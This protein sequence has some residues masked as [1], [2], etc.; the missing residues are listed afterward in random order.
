M[1]TLLISAH[2]VCESMR[3]LNL[4]MASFC[5]KA[6]QRS[7]QFVDLLTSVIEG[8]RGADCALD[9]HAAQDGL[10]AMVSRAYRY[11]LL[12]QGDPN[13]FRSKIVENEREHARLLAGSSDEAQSGYTEQFLGAVI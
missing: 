12:V 2:V 1:K 7:H 4:A 13:I 10:R 8:K 6:Q 3:Q 5:L 11:P 9:A